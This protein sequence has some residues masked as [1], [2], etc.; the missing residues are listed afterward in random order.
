[1]HEAALVNLMAAVCLKR[2]VEWLYDGYAAERSLALLVSDYTFAFL[3]V[4]S[5]FFVVADEARGCDRVRSARKSDD[6]GA[7]ESPG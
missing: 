2:R 3:P 5:R 6:C 7:S 1:M 4:S